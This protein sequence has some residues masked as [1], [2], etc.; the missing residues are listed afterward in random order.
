MPL[1][2]KELNDTVLR[3]RFSFELHKPNVVALSAFENS[4]NTQSKFVVSRVDNHVF[5]RIPKTEQQFSSPQLHLEIIPSDDGNN[6]TVK[7]L[8]SPNPT[9]WT[10][11]M[12]LHFVIVMLFLGNSVWMYSNWSLKKPLTLQIIIYIVLVATWITLY[13]IGQSNKKKNIPQMLEQ[14]HFMRDVLRTL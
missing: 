2:N 10:L 9:I 4:K 14:H 3:P 13:L 8:F 6:S 7:G 1:A 11:F 5:I 12:F